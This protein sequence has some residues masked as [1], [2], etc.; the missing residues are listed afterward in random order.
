VKF[1]E[2]IVEKID[3]L[4]LYYATRMHLGTKKSCSILLKH[5]N[6]IGIALDF[7]DQA[8][9]ELMNVSLALVWY[10]WLQCKV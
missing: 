8:T 2:L 9:K 3:S 1:C 6:R 4:E 5:M 10:C 7:G